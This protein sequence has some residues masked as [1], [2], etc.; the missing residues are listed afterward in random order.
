MGRG[1][2]AGHGPR[3]PGI[4]LWCGRRA[5][6]PAFLFYQSVVDLQARASLRSTAE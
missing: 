6:H 5:S 4:L 2:D 3:L 1:G